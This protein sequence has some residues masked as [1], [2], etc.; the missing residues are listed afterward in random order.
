MLFVYT[1]THISVRTVVRKFVYA[2]I[3]IPLHASAL[4]IAYM[5]IRS[6]YLRIF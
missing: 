2:Q 3:C 5:Y 4:R 1:M 6:Q